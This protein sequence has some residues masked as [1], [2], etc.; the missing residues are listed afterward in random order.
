METQSTTSKK[1]FFQN[2]RLLVFSMLVFYG[3]CVLGCVV[4]VFWGLNRT[5]QTI[6]A[7]TTSTASVHAT[8]RAMGTATALVRTADQDTYEF[9]EHFDQISGRWFVGVYNKRYSDARIAIKDD[10]Y[11]WNIA[12]SK[13]YT[14]ST[15]F[16][17]GNKLKDFDIYMDLK[18]VESSRLGAVCSGFFLR[19]PSQAWTDGAY[20]FTICNDS[21]YEIQFFSEEGWQTITNSDYES[22]IDRSGW[23]RIGISTSGTRFEF[24]INNL[25]VFEMTDD[26]LQMGSLGIFI[27]MDKGNSAEIWFDNF[28]YRSR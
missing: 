24:I 26:R 7:N 16:Y 28:G 6:S 3:I 8:E 18:F 5:N 20:I 19:R 23:N 21:H 13:D 9:I 11:I 4:A 22:I 27:D 10:V 25:T 17:K 15:D 2:D 12:N 1:S 14:M